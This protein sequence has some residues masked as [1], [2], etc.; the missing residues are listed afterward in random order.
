HSSFRRDMSTITAV[1]L[2]A[3]LTITVGLGLGEQGMNLRCRC[4]SKERKPIG[5]HI[6]KLE[7]IP[8]NSHCEEVEIIAT[9]KGSG[10]LVFHM[11]FMTLCAF[12][13][14]QPPCSSL[15]L[16]MCF[17]NQFNQ[18]KD[19]VVAYT[20]ITIMYKVCKLTFRNLEISAIIIFVSNE[21][22]TW[23]QNDLNLSL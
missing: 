7:V 22:T 4:I 8:A 5:R 20:V 11:S 17:L 21:L 2:L 23:V 15:C 9:L 6:E 1:A 10:L 18:V 14:S 13:F 12:L 16:T 3:F 19:K